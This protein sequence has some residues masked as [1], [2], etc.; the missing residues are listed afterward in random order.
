MR[1]SLLATR[2]ENLA[3]PAPPILA[4]PEGVPSDTPIRLNLNE[5]P[6]SPSPRAIDAMQSAIR[7][8]NFYPDHGCTALV[9]ALSEKLSLIHI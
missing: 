8:V 2:V 4:E 1:K 3:F 5:S 7:S 9:N 6:Y